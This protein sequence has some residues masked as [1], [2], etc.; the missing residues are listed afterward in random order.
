M[1]KPQLNPDNNASPFDPADSILRQQRDVRNATALAGEENPDQAA[2]ALDLSD[3]TGL[4]A[5]VIYPNLD[6]FEN[7][8]KAALTNELLRNNQFLTDYANH[9]PMAPIVSN[10][11]WGNLDKAGE[12][13]HKLTKTANRSVWD[14]ATSGAGHGLATGLGSQVS[15]LGRMIGSDQIAGLNERITQNIERNEPISEEDQQSL[16]YL[17]GEGLGQLL[18][19]IPAGM[20]G[21]LP[22]IAIGMGLQS[23][24]TEAEK[25]IKEGASWQTPFVG[26]F[27]GGALMAKL[28]LG[29]IDKYI[30]RGAEPGV[31]NWASQR[32]KEAVASG[33]TLGGVSELGAA[34]SAALEHETYDP[35]AKYSFD[36]KRFLANVI[37]GAILGPTFGSIKP[38]VD[39]GERIPPGAHPLTDAISFEKTKVDNEALDQALK[40]AQATNTQGRR[41]AFLSA[42]YKFFPH[43]TMGLDGE[44]VLELYGNKP[45]SPD[46]GILGFLPNIADQLDRA[47]TDGSDIS[48]P[49]ADYVAHIDPSIDKELHDFRRVDPDGMTL[50]DTKNLYA[51][52]GE[53]DQEPEEAPGETRQ[54]FPEMTADTA[55]EPT[56]TMEIKGALS[57]SG[58]EVLDAV[59]KEN[60]LD[61]IFPLPKY[62]QQM[63]GGEVGRE[64][65]PRRKIDWRLNAG[66]RNMKEFADRDFPFQAVG[67]MKTSEV[68]SNVDTKILTKIP[69]VLHQFFGEQL[70]KLVGDVPVYIVS[71]DTMRKMQAPYP[72]SPAFYQE[73]GTPTAT[74]QGGIV[75]SESLFTGRLGYDY[76]AHGIIHEAAHAASVQAMDHDPRLAN[77]IKAVR[78]FTADWLKKND[79]TA[80]DDPGIDYAFKHGPH[81]DY[82]FI[83]QGWSEPRFQDLINTI[84]LPEKLRSSIGVPKAGTIWEAAKGL[85]K[86]AL[87]SIMGRHVPESVM[88][89]MFKFGDRFQEFREKILG[90]EVP[91]RRPDQPEFRDEP[92]PTPEERQLFENQRTLGYSKKHWDRIKGKLE[93]QRAEDLEFNKQQALKDA[94][95]RQTQRWK[96]NEDALRP[97]AEKTIQNRPYVAADRYFRQGMLGPNKVTRVRMDAQYLTDEQKQQL[98]P[99]WYGTGRQFGERAVVNPDDV[100]GLFGY[101]SGSSMISDLILMNRERERAGLT[102]SAHV[103]HLQDVELER[104]MKA[105]FGSLEKN[106]LE[107]ARDHIIN[108][109]QFNL[110]HEDTLRLAAK[111]GIQGE[112]W[113][114]SDIKLMA[115]KSLDDE[116]KVGALKSTRISDNTARIGRDIED[117]ENRGDMQTVL[118]LAQAREISFYKTIEARKFEK[119]QARVEKII[120]RHKRI[121]LTGFK[122]E[123]SAAYHDFIQILMWEGGFRPNRRLEDLRNEVRKKGFEHLRDFVEKADQQRNETIPA[124]DWI[125]NNEHLDPNHK[126]SVDEFTVGEGRSY[127]NLIKALDKLGR[128]R[129]KYNKEGRMIDLLAG[130]LPQAIDEIQ[131]FDLVE[132]G[133]TK[134]PLS[135]FHKGFKLFDVS[136]R[137]MERMLNRFDKD[138]PRGPLNQF[139]VR[140]FTSAANAKE[141][142]DRKYGGKLRELGLPDNLKQT[143][144]SP[145]LN[146]TTGRP[147][148]QFT[149]KNLLSLML[150]MGSE[151]NW[152]KLTQGWKIDPDT[153][154][155]WVMNTATE[156]E[157]K[158]VQGVWDVFKDL[159]ED[160]DGVYRRTTGT[161]PGTKHFRELDT[162]FGQ[163]LTGGYYPLIR[164]DRAT[165]R[166]SRTATQ[167]VKDGPGFYRESIPNPHARA[168]TGEVYQVSFD[169]D[170]MITKYRQMVH[171]IAFREA[172]HESRKVLDYQP[173]RD[174]IVNHYGQEYNQAIN[175]WLKFITHS[176]EYNDAAGRLGEKVSEF[177]RQNVISYYVGFNPG[178]VFKHGPTAFVNSAN[179][180]GFNRLLKA[181]ATILNEAPDGKGSMWNWAI[182]NSEELQRRERFWRETF[183]GTYSEL[184]KQTFRQTVIDWGAKPVAFSDKASAVPMWIAA[185]EKARDEGQ[186]HGESVFEADRAVRF[187][188]GS[189]S[190]TNLPRIARGRGIHAWFTSLYGFFGTM[191]Q[192][193]MDLA[194][195]VNDAWKLME[196]KQ[197]DQ[198]AKM[199]PLIAADTFAYVIWP[200]F[201][202]ELVTGFWTDDHRGWGQRLAWATAEGLASSVIYARDLVHTL[203]YG[204][205]NSG[206]LMGSA[207]QP[208]RQ[209]TADVADGKQT[210]G[211]QRSSHLIQDIGWLAG[212]FS[213][214]PKAVSNAARFGYDTYIVQRDHPR[215]FGDY[216][217]G[218]TKGDPKARKV[219]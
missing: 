142:I 87:E 89:S 107:D 20:I 61:K 199:L 33:L 148:I 115:E 68:L 175:D 105:K 170:Q 130:P 172:L 207:L 136:L 36:T 96:E 27:A 74:R 150:N 18:S 166:G 196:N 104:M 212:I 188:H 167:D 108:D 85:I 66:P 57:D 132:E 11:D 137:T 24:E 109:G 144:D 141:V 38:F 106:I 189:T 84:P 90:K 3:A 6:N 198:A 81:T 179:E 58:H 83:A 44:K 190:I 19:L 192:N 29:M 7:Q 138:N 55:L 112:P 100:A 51:A 97:E 157:W 28:P 208:L 41:A 120:N 197:M 156:E 140:P 160:L 154:H 180:V 174:A 178:T 99:E 169:L 102:H 98:S 113:T 75:M 119:L 193:R 194:F 114:K 216:F 78:E 215:T 191:M 12:S 63:F 176:A 17:V 186:T 149:R 42:Y 124:P 173:L 76:A 82:E 26:G 209:I 40:D 62:M 139:V 79:P 22:G 91:E 168:V 30:A 152:A 185:Y 163:H 204:V 202:E 171:D 184:Q 133:E 67:V 203:E 37:G 151:E 121:E 164:Y 131:R 123:D 92:L 59:R 45:P 65:V 47:R 118:R 13:Y 5:S 25:A 129:F 94:T 53:E 31:I 117:A 39:A 206:G 70:Q 88:D 110:L 111:Y 72:P 146:P 34:Y 159:K 95:Q 177:F 48:I 145:F 73:A 127:Y 21:G 165:G 43:A 1:P 4:P 126:G 93:K 16:S 50:D 217:R 46:D 103:S 195:K 80:R 9:D 128:E 182:R 162:P 101:R 77:D 10:D 69:K 8:H 125:L 64:L 219:K 210:L 213:G 122:D 14:L 143:L 15:A 181:Y 205:D 32:L 2:R 60:G 23:A 161:P 134:G 135:A 155:N 54:A 153:L 218:I 86:R 35:D 158:W 147:L 214:V 183:G 187:A 200:T 71:D 211:K 49:L 116:T 201:I 56:K 52:P